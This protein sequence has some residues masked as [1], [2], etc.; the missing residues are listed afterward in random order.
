MMNYKGYIAVA[1]YDD[2][3]EIFHGEVVN[4]RDVITFQGEVAKELKQAMID[5]IEAHIAFCQKKGIEPSKPFPGEFLVRTTPEKHGLFTAAARASGLSLNKWVDS[6]LE[7]AAR[8]LVH[9]G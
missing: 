1:H 8:D 9:Y 3:A 2:E 4:T 6:V 5:S 7:H